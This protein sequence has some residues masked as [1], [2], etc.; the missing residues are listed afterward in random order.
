M[1]KQRKNAKPHS[2]FK[3][4]VSEIHNSEYELIGEYVSSSKK[5]EI[6]HKLC[7]KSWS[8]RADTFI[9][10][11]AHCPF[12]T[13][14]KRKERM[15]SNTREFKEKVYKMYK[16]E[17]SVLGNYQGVR[18]YILMRHN[19]CEREYLIN[20]NSFLS[21]SRCAKCFGTLKK[22]TEQFEKEVYELVGEDY[23]VLGEYNNSQTRIKMKH[24]VC[25][26]TYYVKPN[27]FMMGNRCPKCKFSKGEHSIAMYLDERKIQYIKE[28]K[29]KECSYILPLPFD[30][31]IFKN[32]ELVSL[33]EFDGE[34]HFIAKSKFG[35]EIGLKET[36]NRDKI[37]SDY[38][39][40]HN[41][42]LIRIKYDEFKYKQANIVRILNEKLLPL[43]Q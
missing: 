42:N 7:K 28:Y 4:E 32:G 16:D 26:H 17:Y 25:G 33:V 34:Q 8:P 11:H 23:S 43:M 18:T 30:F 14:V 22:T 2:Q 21:G 6:L 37:K 19:K 9:Q 38:C 31:A 13:K 1:V 40:E 24:V 15:E 3:K 20:P 10:G 27:K 29:I 12:C 5:V 41:I 39:Y 35:G 36:Q